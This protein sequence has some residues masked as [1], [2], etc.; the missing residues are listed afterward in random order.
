MISLESRA[1]LLWD[2]LLLAAGSLSIFLVSYEIALI[3]EPRV[4][5]SLIVYAIDGVFLADIWF[6]S[7]TTFRAFGVEVRDPDRIKERYRRRRLPIILVGAIPFD[8]VLLAFD[9]MPWGVSLVL[10]FRLLRLVRVEVVFGTIKRL[11]RNARSNSAA[12]RIIN[13]VVVAAVVLHLLACAWYLMAFATGFPADSWA[14]GESLAS[15][16]TGGSY[17][18]SLYWVVTTA[19]TVGF[20]DIAPGNTEEYIFGLGVMLIGASLFAYVIATGASLVSSLNLSKV[21]FWNRVDTVESYLRSRRVETSVSHEVRGYYEYLWDRHS[22]VSERSLL[23]DL[24]GPLRLRVLTELMRDLLPNVPLFAHSPPALR[25]ELLLSLTPVITQP[26]GYLVR[27]G[28]V[29]DG[30]YFIADGG[31][32]VVSTGADEPHARLGPGDYFGELTLMLEERRTASVRSI[33]FTEVFW[34][35]STAFK[36]IREDYSEFRDVLTKSSSDRSPTLAE[37]VLDGIVL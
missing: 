23:G 7:R 3:H 18:R 30:I 5:T 6:G 21:A 33:G 27:E 9:G 13:L 15:E 29:A 19:T 12:L 2:V 22:G 26:G 11:E 4:L 16:T 36:R 28:E 32:E 1:R 14:V 31:V 20:G 17:L 10:W 34:L 24:P 25:D 37:L 8:L 35:D